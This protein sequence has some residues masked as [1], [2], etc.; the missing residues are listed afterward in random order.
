MR[1]MTL[2]LLQTLFLSSVFAL[3]IDSQV[4]LRDAAKSWVSMDGQPLFYTSSNS[5]YMIDNQAIRKLPAY[6]SEAIISLSPT[7]D[8]RLISML[9]NLGEI[10]NGKR[11]SD[12]FVLDDH[13]D[14]MYAVNM[15]TESDLKPH[16]AAISD[17]GVLALVDPVKA[18][19]YFYVSGNLIAEGQL[20]E[21]DGDMSLERNVLMQWI[22]EK[23]Y[24]LLER[25]GFNGGPAGK[26]LFISINSNGRGQRTSYLPFSYLQ[27]FVFQNQRFFAS[28]YDYS[29]ADKEI[30][31]LIVELSARG[32]VLWSNE[33]FGHELHLSPNGSY[34]AALSSHEFIQLFELSPKRVQKIRFDN[35][36]KVCLGLS[37]NNRG[38]VA[39]IRVAADFFAKRNTHFSQIFFPQTESSTDIQIDPRFP[40]LFQVDT[41]G[42]RFFIGTNYEWLEISQ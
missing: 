18:L 3:Q 20:Y 23:C 4:T 13:N 26:S 27:D 24:I 8:Y 17:K 7:G 28:G 31:P 14:L 41:D 33:N 16:V 1:K 11:Y 39:V 25:P 5:Q 22:G 40:L 29:A 12:Y 15:G 30:Q 38:E 21:D 10:K 19:I 42:D 2:L 6:S 9:K 34:L 32:E 35:D 37:V 36:N